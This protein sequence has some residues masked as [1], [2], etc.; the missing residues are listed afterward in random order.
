MKNLD[1]IKLSGE[2]ANSLLEASLDKLGVTKNV[3]KS[4][5]W[6]GRTEF[7]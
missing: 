2:L 3:L 4:D 5:F 1:F 6:T 7:Q